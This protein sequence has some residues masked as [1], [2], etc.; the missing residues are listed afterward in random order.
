MKISK[1]KK[2]LQIELISQQTLNFWK[3]NP[4]IHTKEMIEKLSAL[5]IIHGIRSPLIVWKNN[6][7][8]YKGNLSLK[9]LRVLEYKKVPV[10]FHDFKNEAQAVAY[11]ISDNKSSEFAEWDDDVL[12]KLLQTEQL[13][14][15]PEET[16]YTEHEFEMIKQFEELEETIVHPLTDA[17]IIPPFSILDARQGYWVE[18][19]Q[20]WIALG[21]QGALGRDNKSTNANIPNKDG[22]L[23]IDS[24]RGKGHKGYKLANKHNIGLS[25]KD[26]KALGC[27][28][29]IG[30]VAIDREAGRVGTSVFDPVL[31]EIM[32]LWFCLQGGHILDPFAGESSKGIVAT[33]LGYN[34][35]GIELRQ[36]QVD[37]NV[38]QAKKIGVKPNWIVGD[39][40]EIS[41]L[42]PQRANYDMIFTSPPYYDLEIYSEDIKD[43]S[44]FET[45]DKFIKW[46]GVIYAQVI[47][48]LV[49][50]RFVVVKVGEIRDEKGVY[51]NFVADNIKCFTELG[52]HYYNEMILITSIGSLPI[53]IRKQFDSGRKI[54][55]THQNILVFYKGDLKEIRNIFG[56][57]IKRKKVG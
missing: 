35:T 43:G 54:G 21:I 9:V 2:S 56:K 20:E 5:I 23:V 39:S 33:Y 24:Y 48:R 26:K 41:S 40:S 17:Y 18:R 37:A 10:I 36:E 44:V 57:R 45:Y 8:V 14:L 6:M 53:R 32:Y 52:L 7:T 12:S 30:G 22:V 16:G 27:Y 42:L 50:N 4:R 46:L 49:S 25:E 47:N 15:T 29:A 31:S 55:K 11:A 19:K 28:G 13:D 51:R 34:Y 38:I 3:D 1:I